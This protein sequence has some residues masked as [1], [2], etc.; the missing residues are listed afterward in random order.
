[1]TNDQWQ[2]TLSCV[3]GLRLIRFADRFWKQSVQS[4]YNP[5]VGRLSPKASSQ[6]AF[7][8]TCFFSFSHQRDWKVRQLPSKASSLAKPAYSQRRSHHLILWVVTPAL[9]VIFAQLE[10]NLNLWSRTSRQIDLFAKVF[11]IWCLV[12]G[13]PTSLYVGLF[14]K[15]NTKYKKTKHM[16][17][18]IF[19]EFSI[20]IP[21]KY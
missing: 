1:M 9:S 13:D 17:N 7:L 11:C 19:Y 18:S 8:V 21:R 14:L 10:Y 3:V 4:G 15:Q 20:L 2:M 12:F 5:V 6:G 16:L